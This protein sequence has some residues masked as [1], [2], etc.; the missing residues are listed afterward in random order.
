MTPDE[1]EEIQRDEGLLDAD[2]V[3]YWAAETD[4][5]A[6]LSEL[7]AR[8]DRYYDY[9]STSGLY[10]VWLRSYKA[11]YGGAIGKNALKG[12][13]FD[14]SAIQK[15]GRSGE[16]DVLVQ[17]HYQSIISYL[18]TLAC[19]ERPAFQCQ[20]STSDYDSLSAGIIGN[21]IIDYYLDDKALYPK[22]K[23]DCENA[24]LFGLGE[25]SFTW[26][27]D[28]GNDVETSEDGVI[29]KEGDVEPE[30]HTPLDVIRDYNLR[31]TGGDAHFWK[32]IRTFA[33]RYDLIVKYPDKKEELLAEHDQP[34]YE[35]Y[36]SFLMDIDYTRNEDS[37]FIPVYTFFHK[38]CPAMPEGR[39]VIHTCSVVLYDGPNI[40]EKIPIFEVMPL[41]LKGTCFGFSPLWGLLADQEMLNRC[42]SIISTNISA[43]GLEG[44]YC[45]DPELRITKIGQKTLYT[46][47]E[48]PEPINLVNTS[49]EI[50][51][52]RRDLIQDMGQLSGMNDVIRGNPSSNIQSGNYAA[53]MVA[54][55]VQ[56]STQLQDSYENHLS[57]SATELINQLMLFAQSERVIK[58]AGKENRPIVTSFRPDDLEGINKVTVQR[59]NPMARTMGGRIE[60]MRMAQEQGFQLTMGEWYNFMCTGRLDATSI[61]E[62]QQEELSIQ[63]ENEKLQDFQ[64][65]SVLFSENHKKHIDRHL[66][67]LSKPG[68]KENPQLVQTIQGHVQE[69]IDQWMTMTVQNPQMLALTGQ[70]PIP[71]PTMAPPQGPGQPPQGPGSMTAPDQ[72]GMSAGEQQPANLP[73][74]PPGAPPQAQAAF[75]QFAGASQGGPIA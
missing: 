54:Q 14:G 63:L 44:I 23:E 7:N 5:D 36:D 30:V 52:Y 69:H 25:I 41:R 31:K 46:A 56:A 50:Y 39:I 2:E 73:S 75:E 70:Q 34:A 38:P 68:A 72:P 49:A 29:M 43:Y 66:A 20:A 51:N 15:D 42:N 19:G 9:L 33:N 40:Y 8:I 65:V 13:L 27:T 11:Y 35:N 21:N 67:L 28:L 6:L 59:I 53:L 58:L 12:N 10:W 61:N 22:F 47:A 18:L 37:D 32:S 17:N 3:I 26:N 57:E 55:G 24:I 71:L 48:K 62:A 1:L 74:L 60:L 4:E 45:K 16:I 64:P